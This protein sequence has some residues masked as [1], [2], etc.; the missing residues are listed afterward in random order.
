M[1]VLLLEGRCLVVIVHLLLGLIGFGRAVN[2]FSHFPSLGVQH[3]FTNRRGNRSSNTKNS[4]S[5][6]VI[7]ASYNPTSSFLPESSEE[8][9]FYEEDDNEEKNQMRMEVKKQLERAIERSLGVRPWSI[10]KSLSRANK[11]SL[12][13]KLITAN[14]LGF[15]LQCLA[16][17]VTTF[18]IK[19]SDLILQGQQLYRLIT[20][21]FL[22]GNAIHLI[23]N[24]YSLQ[25]I[26]PEVER[27]F[28]PGRF[29]AAYLVSGVAGNVFSSIYTPNP[30]LGA[31]GAIFGLVGAY[32]IFLH[33]N[34]KLF[35][36]SGRMQMDSVTR[37]MLLNVAFGFASPNI[38]NWAHI[39][40]AVG[41]AFMAEA[42]GPKLLVMGLP[43]GARIIVDKPT[44]RLPR[45][46]ESIPDQITDKF[47]R[48]QRRMRVDRFQSDLSIKPW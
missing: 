5:D 44:I 26:G 41:G 31:S 18:G 20:P 35:G 25:N 40:G 39:G 3:T 16:P 8:D 34:G 38:D 42:F 32:Y 22:H 24:T 27:M 29:M 48:V 11:Y 14:V 4:R 6:V 37:T 17:S 46:I 36:R 28:G 7:S 10:E 13:S 45:S 30:S 43:N 1:K 47:T 2:P 33:R 15:A 21:I 12:T 19:R 23:M 9:D